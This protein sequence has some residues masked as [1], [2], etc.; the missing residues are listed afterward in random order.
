MERR[1]ERHDQARRVC[2]RESAETSMP[3]RR[4][5]QK[6]R[7]RVRG[8]RQGL[9]PRMRRRR[10]G[11]APLAEIALLAPWVIAARLGRFADTRP[12]SRMRNLD[13]ATRMVTE[14]GAALAES[15]WAAGAALMRAQWGMFESLLSAGNEIAA[16]ASHPVGKRVRR[17]ARRLRRG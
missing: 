3:N 1:D 5:R 14:K 15:S 11:I 9:T 10:T 4:L 6:Q 13:E 12:K 17:N 16:A 2:A 7:A 8:R